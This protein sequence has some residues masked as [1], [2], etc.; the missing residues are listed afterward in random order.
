MARVLSEYG[1]TV[2]K[3]YQ[4]YGGCP[5]PRVEI[6]R[7]FLRS[8]D[9]WLSS[10]A[11]TNVLLM[12]CERGA[13]PVLAFMLASLLLYRKKQDGEQKTLNMIYNKAP[14]ELLQLTSTLNPLP[15]QLR[16]LQ[17]VSM[18]NAG[19]DWPAPNKLLVIK[20][21]RLS[22]IPHLDVQWGCQI[23]GPEPFIFADQTPKV[24][25]ST[26]YEQSANQAAKDHCCTVLH[27]TFCKN[28]NYATFENLAK[29]L[30]AR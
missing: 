25:S 9:E 19:S 21:V 20:S 22:S 16:Y 15:S 3:H 23:I 18:Q 30:F 7:N 14:H 11:K 2:I 27:F 28:A 24:L 8:A 26:P 10:D 5:I 1:I 4:N 13:W 6:I 12:H 29:F 17:Y